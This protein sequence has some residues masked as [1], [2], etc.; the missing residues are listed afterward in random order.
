MQSD[1]FDRSGSHASRPAAS[2]LYDMTRTR[3][4]P[5]IESGFSADEGAPPAGS[6]WYGSG[7]LMMIGSQDIHDQRNLRW[8]IAAFSRETA[9][10]RKEIPLQRFMACDGGSLSTGR[11]TDWSAPASRELRAGKGVVL[12]LLM[13][14]SSQSLRSKV[15][16]TLEARGVSLVRGPTDRGEVQV[17][18]RFVQ[19]LLTAAEDP[20]VSIGTFAG[21]V[22][23]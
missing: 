11:G 13:T 17:D 16:D 23:V 2:V 15:M 21:G 6:G 19:L 10:A 8:P 7:K 12:L 20:E 14:R 3:E 1:A 5:D 4:E 22:R 9:T 18:Y